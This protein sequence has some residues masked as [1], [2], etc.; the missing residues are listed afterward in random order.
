MKRKALQ[1]LVCLTRKPE[2]GKDDIVHKSSIQQGRD[3]A[4]SS[5]LAFWEGS[6]WGPGSGHLFASPPP[7]RPAADCQI[8]QMAVRLVMQFLRM[9]PANLSRLYLHYRVRLGRKRLGYS[10]SL[11]LL[12]ENSSLASLSLSLSFNKRTEMTQ[13]KKGPGRTAHLSPQLHG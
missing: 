10:S 13:A 2:A 4:P 1:F 7:P 11:W 3:S 5:S 9:M 12:G 8:P 6:R